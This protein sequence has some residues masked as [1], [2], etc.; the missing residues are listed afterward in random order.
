[1]KKLLIIKT[2]TIGQSIKD[3]FGDFEH[4]ICEQL[5]ISLDQAMVVPVYEGALLPESLD[6][7]SSVIITGSKAMVTDALAWTKYVSKWI[8]DLAQKDIPILGI[9]YGHQLLAHA[10]G[11]E[12]DYHPRGEEYGDTTVQLTGEGKEDKLF[13]G[14]PSAIRAYVAHAQTV[15]KVPTDAVVLARNAFEEHHALRFRD[16]VWGVQFHPEFTADLLKEYMQL[17]RERIANQGYDVDEL[18]HTAQDHAYGKTLL[19]KF[20]AI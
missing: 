1:M 18:L 16:N 19:K 20:I 11:G 9:C 10:L 3:K 6:S 4:L 8:F 12:V 13:A 7:I 5:E 2:G 15:K 14:L 17:G